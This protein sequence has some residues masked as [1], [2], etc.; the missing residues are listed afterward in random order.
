M[1]IN[2]WSSLAA[3]IPGLTVDAQAESSFADILAR[4]QSASVEQTDAMTALRKEITDWLKKDPVE[5]LRDAILEDLGLSEESLSQLSPEQQA[6]IEDYIAEKIKEKLLAATG[7]PP[8]QSASQ[9]SVLQ[10][11]QSQF[12]RSGAISES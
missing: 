6:A 11:L 9:L 3:L 10:A 8:P 7:I 4:T 12:Q 2:Q 5:H 1:K